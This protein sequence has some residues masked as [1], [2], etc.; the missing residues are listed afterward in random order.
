M[1][2]YDITGNALLSTAAAALDPAHLAAETDVAEALLGVQ[3]TN[4]TDVPPTYALT[5]VVEALAL[6]VSFQLLIGTSAFVY[7]SETRGSR[8]VTY[9]AGRS[10]SLSAIDPRALALVR[11]LRGYDGWTTVRTLRPSSAS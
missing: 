2:T 5:R 1:P 8:S 11:S 10:T 3:G 7:A 9:R 4:Y 6:Q